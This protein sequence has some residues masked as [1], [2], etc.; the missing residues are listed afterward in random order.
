MHLAGDLRRPR[1]ILC[2]Y[3]VVLA[4]CTG[5]LT[6]GVATA[7]TKAE[8]AARWVGRLAEAE[9]VEQARDHLRE[10]GKA[11]LGALQ[12]GLKHPD[13]NVRAESAFVLGRI[14][15][16]RG[17]EP[18]IAALSDKSVRVRE[19]S[20]YALGELADE[21][22]VEALLGLLE[23]KETPVRANAVF[24][25]GQIG[26]K[27]GT[28]GLI[29]ALCDSEVLVRNHAASALGFTDDDRALGPLVWVIKNEKEV[30]V[31]A[32]ATSSLAA[33][34][35]P[36]ASGVLI[37]LLSDPDVLVR[38]RAIDGL[39]Q[40][41]GNR[42]DYNPRHDRRRRAASVASWKTWYA[43]NRE[44]LGVIKP[45]DPHASRDPKPEEPAAKPTPPEPKPIP[46]DPPQEAPI[47]PVPAPDKETLT[48]GLI[49]PDGPAVT[50]PEAALPD[51]KQGMKLYEAGN[52]ADALVRFQ[53]ALGQGP[54]NS[55]LLYNIA[56]VQQRL[57]D[58][59]AARKTYSALLERHAGYRPA[60]N[61]L[62]VLYQK[63]A[64]SV[65]PRATTAKRFASTPTVPICMP[66]TT[67]R[68]CSQG[69]MRS[70]KRLRA[71]TSS[72]SAT[73]AFPTNCPRRSFM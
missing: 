2:L 20:A 54:D 40:L 69:A 15:S 61:N 37:D 7:D 51:F 18:L 70:K 19:K 5:V 57:G 41:T 23:D 34:R 71:M 62:G 31:R 64:K 8:Q 12:E 22:A 10:L 65:P 66:V 4:V 60:L 32:L 29:R 46:Q 59:E 68:A 14:G 52:L 58:L 73:R 42:Y 26:S 49:G 39:S 53:A 9:R 38:S 28:E 55:T 43:R 35:R 36:A 30:E 56:L 1:A 50:L 63:L 24:A 3:R 6:V 48:V 27:Q 21:R 11:A 45:V 13:E 72:G 16:S 17:V 67:S 33:L 47:A 44:K 25:L